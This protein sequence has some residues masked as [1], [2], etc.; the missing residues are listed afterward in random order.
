MQAREGPEQ[1]E[2]DGGDREPAPQPDA[3]QP[4]RRR[5]DDGKVDIQRPEVGFLR[6]N[7]HRGD[8]RGR[9]AETRERWA[10]QQRRGQRAQRHHAQE[11][12]CGRGYQKIV[13][14][15]G[16]VD[17]SESNGGPGG[18]ENRGDIGDRQRFDRGDALLAARPF[19]CCKQCQR[20]RAA[21]Q[22]ANAGPKQSRV[23]GIADHEETAE[24]QRQSADPD[25]P[26]GADTLLEAR[27]GLWE[28]RR[29]R[30]RSAVGVL[31]RR[32]P[33][34]RGR[35][36]RFRLFSRNARRCCYRGLL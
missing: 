11:N 8:E 19:A 14:R 4:E 21:Q 15:V 25:H 36:E 30:C 3:R 20:E 32:V 7:Q 33:V 23:N 18:G 9:D 1:R 2:D 34:V 16:S 27:P 10:V 12:E 22:N 5:S 29:R 28:R 35:R 24:R 31:R 13:K 6:R 26:A 17:G